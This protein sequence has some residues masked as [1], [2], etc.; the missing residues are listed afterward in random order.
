MKLYYR[1]LT[2]EYNS[3]EVAKK[4]TKPFEP[5][6]HQ[7][8]AYNLT[9]RGTTYRVDPNIEPTPVPAPTVAYQLMYR[10]IVYSVQRTH[11]GEVSTTSSQPGNC[12]SAMKPKSILITDSYN[13][14]QIPNFFNSNL[15]LS[16]FIQAIS[17]LFL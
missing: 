4:S 1:G 14:N 13:H 16:R 8:S 10:G 5:V 12:V 3:S 9:Y 11:T 6:C 7:G 17:G 15:S 2:Y